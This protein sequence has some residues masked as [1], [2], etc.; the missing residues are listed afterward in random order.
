LGAARCA[1]PDEQPA[2]AEDLLDYLRAPGLLERPEI[3]DGL[4]AEVRRTGMRTATQARER[5][6]W[7]LG[8]LDSLG[9]ASDPGEELIRLAGR[10]FAA[11]HRGA[12]PDLDH[13]QELDA[14]A[15]AALQKALQ[16]LSELRM[17]PAGPEL[18][19][20]LQS[21]P[22]RGPAAAGPGA[23]LLADPAEIR[24]RRFSVVFVCGLQEGEFPLPARPEPFLS[25]ERRWE[26]AAASGLRLS[27]REDSLAGERYLFYAAVSRA[28][29]RV[30]LSYR[31]S[32]EEGNRLGS[33]PGPNRA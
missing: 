2:R 8:E 33:R 21:L 20:L 31:S 10:L 4:E 18:I 12:A 17:A 5:L 1:F 28:T 24:A 22:V 27:A 15:L 32:D 23:V 26:L 11:P 14:R 3:A 9:A 30:F 7:H 13:A 25:D 29:V 6:G 16:E 19:E